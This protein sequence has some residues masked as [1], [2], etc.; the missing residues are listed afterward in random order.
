MRPTSDREEFHRMLTSIAKRRLLSAAAGALLASSLLLGACSK[1]NG[2]AASSS[3][4]V[5]SP[6]VISDPAAYVA[7]I[8]ASGAAWKRALQQ[9][10]SDFTSAE[11]GVTDLSAIRQALVDYLNALA[12]DT[13]T[14]ASA[15]EGAGVPPIADGASVQADLLAGF[16]SVAQAFREDAAQAQSLSTS[17]PTAFS[18]GVSRLAVTIGKETTAMG[19]SLNSAAG[20]VLGPLIKD[21]PDCN[22]SGGAG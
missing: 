1:S 10:A 12:T 13:D 14:F 21:N 9:R 15:V 18:T 6:S 22:P 16:R 2:T 17:D 7:N 5:T 11:T 4:P 3:A 20:P 19:R 8:C